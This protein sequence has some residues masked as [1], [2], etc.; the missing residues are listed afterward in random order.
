MYL[1]QSAYTILKYDLI[2]VNRLH[3]INANILTLYIE[4]FYKMNISNLNSYD[5]VTLLFGFDN[6]EKLY[7]LTEI[8]KKHVNLES[9]LVEDNLLIKRN[10][11]YYLAESALLRLF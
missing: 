6:S 7:K 9:V 1:K 2:E 4:Y 11:N 8:D 10:N 3:N 5:R